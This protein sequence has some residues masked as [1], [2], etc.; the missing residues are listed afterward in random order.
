MGA[1]PEAIPVI[2]YLAIC[3]GRPMPADV[4][5]LLLA[6]GVGILFVLALAIAGQRVKE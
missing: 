6:G 2:S 4:A 5:E 3:I 1:A